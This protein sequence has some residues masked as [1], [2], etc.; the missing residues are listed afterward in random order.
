MLLVLLV[1]FAKMGVFVAVNKDESIITDKKL[2]SKNV[3]SLRML[4]LKAKNIGFSANIAVAK[5]ARLKLKYIAQYRKNTP[6][7]I[8]N[9]RE[10]LSF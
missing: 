5:I 1:D 4:L 2:K 8:P 3:I 7:K 10:Y 6:T 9:A